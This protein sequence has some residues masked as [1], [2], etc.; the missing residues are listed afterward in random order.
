MAGMESQITIDDK[1][2]P[3]YKKLSRPEHDTK[4]LHHIQLSDAALL[5]AE[6]W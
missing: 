6:L 3:L 5:R 2:V 1:A 4:L